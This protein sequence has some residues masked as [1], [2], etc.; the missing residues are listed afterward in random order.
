MYLSLKPGIL[1]SREGDQTDARAGRSVGHS[2]GDTRNFGKR[3]GVLPL[4]TAWITR[5]TVGCYLSALLDIYSESD[6]SRPTHV[7]FLLRTASSPSK[8]YCPGG[9]GC[10]FELFA[11]VNTV[12]GT[13]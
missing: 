13:V 6:E 12:P 8:V 9:C 4:R 2:Q 1:F 3:I 7:G 11:V 10:V 5:Q